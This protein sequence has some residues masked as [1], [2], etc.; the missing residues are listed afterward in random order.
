MLEVGRRGGL[1]RCG[2]EAA[3]SPQVPFLALSLSWNHRPIK[4]SIIDLSDVA[5]VTSQNQHCQDR[6]HCRPEPNRR[7]ELH[8]KE[9]PGDRPSVRLLP[10]DQFRLSF[11]AKLF[12]ADCRV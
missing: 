1:I 9:L 12:A 10:E 2:T 7:S 6:P 4:P 8:N 5:V 11:A 3:R